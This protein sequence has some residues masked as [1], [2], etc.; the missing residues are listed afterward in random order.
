M[1]IDKLSPVKSYQ[2]SR[3]DVN[4]LNKQQSLAAVFCT[5]EVRAWPN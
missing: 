5:R 2:P 1:A 4:Q 3:S